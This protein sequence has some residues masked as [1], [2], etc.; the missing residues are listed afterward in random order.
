VKVKSNKVRDIRDYYQDKLEKLYPPEEAGN[1]LNIAF[2]DLL[3]VS[4]LQLVMEPEL[5]LSESELL[6]IHFACKDLLKHKPVQYIVGTT[7]FYDLNLS[8]NKQVLI[9]RPETEELVDWILAENPEPEKI[10]I[11]D[12][13]TGSGAIALALKKNINHA[14]VWACDISTG[15]LDV[16]RQNALSLGLEVNLVLSDILNKTDWSRFPEFDLIVSNPPYVTESDK[17]RM[18]ANVLDYE[19]HGALFVLD[20]DPLVFYRTILEFS[21]N[22][23]KSGGELYFEI[24]EKF[25]EQTKKMFAEHGFMDIDIKKDLSWRDRMARGM[26]K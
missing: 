7:G 1:L 14:E 6:K 4:R 26:K 8:V 17:K 19:P 16:A 3:G 13:G 22:H 24:N 15:A 10:K 9:P 21:K 18:Q 2:E 20:E 11:L 25:G 12:I 23:L 5:R